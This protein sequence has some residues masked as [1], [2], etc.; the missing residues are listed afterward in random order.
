MKPMYYIL[1]G[2][3][4]KPCELM[5]WASSMSNIDGRVVNKTTLPDGTNISTVFLGLDH[6][7]GDGPPVLFETMIFGG[8]HDQEQWRYHTWD[9]AEKGHQEAVKLCFS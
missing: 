7:Y 8:E 6:S 1:E 2:K 9:E 3:E 4:P 5:E